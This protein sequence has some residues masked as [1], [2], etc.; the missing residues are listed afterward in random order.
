M[1]KKDSED[2]SGAESAAGVSLRVGFR[3]RK[4]GSHRTHRCPI[5]S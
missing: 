1:S 3:A 5:G 4:P 2:N